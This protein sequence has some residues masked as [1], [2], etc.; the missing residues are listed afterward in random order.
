MKKLLLIFLMFIVS[1]K[2]YS[3]SWMNSLKSSNPTFQEIQQAFYEWNDNKI[4]KDEE[5]DK[6]DEGKDEEE[7]HF[8]RWEWYWETRVLPDGHFPSPSITW[9]EYQKYISNHPI[10]TNRSASSG[11]W[12]FSGPS[13]SV[14]GYR[15]LGRVNCMA[16][17]PTNANTFWVGTPAGGLWKTTDGGNTWSTNTDN[18]PV[19]GVSDIAI[20]PSNPSIMYIATGDGDMGSLSSVTG[21]AAGDTK[22]IG[23]LKSIDGGTTWNLTGMNWSVTS[24]KLIRRLII[25]PNNPSILMAAA[26][27]GIWR[28]SDGGA[29]W[30]LVQP[31]YFMDL[32]FKPTDPSIVYSS[33]FNLSGN[34]QIYRSLDF[35][36]NWVSVATLS[37]VIRINL[38]VSN[39]RP[40]LVDALCANTSRGLAGLWYSDN[41]GSTFGQ[42]L[43]G[44][45]TNNYLHCSNNAIGIDGQGE[46]D[47]AYALNPNN[48]NEIWI[49][50][51][52]IW[53]S[54][55][56]GINFNLKTY[57][58][59]TAINNCGTNPGVATVHSDQHFIAFHPLQ[60]GTIF[61]CNDGGIYKTTDGGAS[62]TDL[63][64]G[65]Q[66]SQIYRIGTAQT[67][68][69][70]IICGLQDNGT[71]E[72][73]NN[74]WVERNG[75]DGMECII[76]Y[77]NP[78]T[79]YA[80][81]SNG[82]IYRSKN[83]WTNYTTISDNIPNTPDGAWVTPFV[84]H[85]TNPNT[86]FAGYKRLW[87]SDDQGDSW[88]YI[89]PIFSTGVDLRSICV[90]PSNPNTIYVANY[91]SLYQTTNGGTTWNNISSGLPSGVK[92]T[93]ITV[94]PTNSQRVY[95]TLSGYSAGNKVYMSPNGGANWYNYSG[96]LPNVPV[97]CITYQKNTNEGLYIGTDLGVFFT[98]ATM[99]D[100]VPYQSGLPNV[101]VTELEISYSNNKLWAATFGRG[102]WS[103]NLGMPLTPDPYEVNNTISQTYTLPVNFTSQSTSVNTIG[104][105]FHSSDDED[106]Y[107]VILPTGFNYS[108]K[109]RI[110]DENNSANGNSYSVDA[111]FS[112]SKDGGITWTSYIDDTLNSNITF[113]GGGTILFQVLPYLS[114]H[115]GTYLL[116]ISITKTPPKI[117]I[118]QVY[119][120][121]GNATGTY[122][123]DYIELHNRDTL[124][125]DISGYKLMYGASTGLFGAASTNIFTF[126]TS[127]IIPAGGYKL[128]AS[129]TGAGLAN[130]PIAADYTST[131]TIGATTGKVLLGTPFILANTSL[132]AQPA[133]S[134]V[135]VVGYGSTTNESETTPLGSLS[136][137]SAAFRK[138]NGC[139]DTYNNS[140]DFSI[141]SPYPRNSS[142]APYFCDIP[143]SN[144]NNIFA[145][146]TIKICGSSYLLSAGSGFS[147]FVWSTNATTSSINVGS[148]G[149][150][151]CTVSNSAGCVGKDSV[152]V[153]LKLPKQTTLSI[154]KCNSY[155]L[156][157]GV[158]V[159]NSGVYSNIYTASNGCDSTVTVNLTINNTT[160]S[161]NSMNICTSST[162]YIWNGNSYTSSGT[163]SYLTTNSLG[164]DSLAIL[165]LTVKQS[166]SSLTN[167]S[168][169]NTSL[170]YIWN[171]YSYNT[172]GIYTTHLTNVNGCDSSAVLSLTVSNGTPTAPTAVTQR[173]IDTTCG[174]RVYRYTSGLVTNANA[175]AWM[176]PTSLGGISGVTV[177]SG[178]I[179]SS[180]TIRLKYV[181][182]TAASATDSIKVR[183]YSGCGTSVFKAFKLTNG[184]LNPPAAPAS[185]TITPISTNIC[186]NRIYR[187]TAPAL[188]AGTATVARATGYL[189]SFAGSLGANASIDSGTLTGRVVRIKYTSNAAAIA[190]DSVRVKYNSSCGYSLNK[191][192]KLS[193]TVLNPPA[194]PA[195]ITITAIAPSVCG[196]KIY[197]YTAPALPIATTTAGAA[198]GYLW[199][200]TGTLGA[201]ASLDS[202]TLTGRIIRIKFTSNAAATTGD[203]VRVKYNSDCGY[204]TN[205]ALKLT[206]VATTVPAAPASITVTAVSATTCGARTY[207]YAA[208]NLPVATTTASAATGYEWNFVGTLGANATIDSGTANSQVIRV[209]YTNNLAAATG[210][211]VKLRY[212][213]SCG[214]SNYKASKLTNTILNCPVNIPTAKATDIK[215]KELEAELYPNPSAGSFQL[216]IQSGATSPILVKVMSASGQLMKSFIAKPNEVS[217]IGKE[218]KAG[219]YMVIVTQG[220]V[221][222]TI[223]AVKM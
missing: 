46:Y 37:N 79:L 198:T 97:N 8:K 18:L 75:G 164:C 14:G 58:H 110:H 30:S 66:I 82:V 68:D 103:S 88:Y 29:N 133:N 92:I 109:A 222:K 56:G 172:S 11:N 159:T 130:L 108:L 83:N 136:V 158:S 156:P 204:S 101:I 186:G 152:Y 5:Q 48:Y 175:Y 44:T 78:Y 85:P 71:K 9:D 45:S 98:D 149:W 63:S 104:S 111:K 107:K 195:S 114:G 203:S 153:V 61:T 205:K 72:F 80:S 177:D 150:Y 162:P 139:V 219:V 184:V 51:I 201:N 42:Y 13:S 74:G 125:Y 39:N 171:G 31:G 173:L 25:N 174:A 15:G 60:A 43:F 223:K 7:E 120:G 134:I 193:N 169:C 34:A 216:K 155:T 163:Y 191:S 157:W 221:V 3:Q 23:I 124:A 77:T 20:N 218:L 132:S 197:R 211:S 54:S 209:R 55:D 17:H 154:T 145:Q 128:I 182:N 57:G 49:G 129:T 207:R 178:N 127:T 113:I 183:A 115:T 52:N 73:Y 38:A 135:D 59:P 213:S 105:N 188:P 214:Y 41:S 6:E 160:S 36:Q 19:L 165:V 148:S 151:K 119:G 144:L 50:G 199:S 106:F 69:N 206:N 122:K 33:T 123:S 86:L 179:N 70:D 166:T 28:T 1:G 210:D 100:W 118:S 84:L 21:N 194:A 189:W 192:L 112:Y 89:S 212:N 47:L 94:D 142:T 32:E 140:L 143:C 168:I 16:F 161:T 4:E 90:S 76:D 131:L 81:Y 185:I 208:P 95:V 117:S 91:F 96:S 87:K 176:I 65:L 217:N 53:K 146:D 12:T 167:S 170:P 181:S 141:V 24:Q 93:Y 202:G 116:D 138:N 10:N 40:S 27:D 187:Y 200:F 102:L 137:T 215:I 2:I 26:S 180:S 22:S 35:G 196:A 64:N 99:N 62:W 67:I 190:G 220:E 147:S 126:P 121:G